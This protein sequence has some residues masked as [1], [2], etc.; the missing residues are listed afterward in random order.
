MVRE[1]PPFR[2]VRNSSSYEAIKLDFKTLDPILKSLI[3]RCPSLGQ[4]SKTDLISGI[5][6]YTPDGYPIVG[7]SADARGY[8]VANGM[9]GR[10][11]SLAGGAGELLTDLILDGY[12]K[13]DVS[14]V[15]STRFIDLHMN[16]QYLHERCPEVAS[17]FFSS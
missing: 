3:H 1:L 11:L 5:E 9:N 17:K 13:T 14:A 10:G 12:A 8:F 4:C 15:E 6:S 2:R 16:L 7:E